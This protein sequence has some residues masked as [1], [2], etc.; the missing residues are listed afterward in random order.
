MSLARTPEE[1]PIRGSPA[2]FK[3]LLEEKLRDDP[4][5]DTPTTPSSSKRPFL[6]K[7]EGLARYGEK[8]ARGRWVPF[9]KKPKSGGNPPQAMPKKN[10]VAPVPR[11]SGAMV[12][13]AVPKRNQ[14]AP[15]SVSRHDPAAVPK[16][17]CDILFW[18]GRCIVEL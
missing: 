6:R 2:P 8:F 17:V 5:A 4:S 14:V 10:Q 12:D 15:I 9:W 3:L 16:K 13:D 1:M 11:V 7:G 18:M